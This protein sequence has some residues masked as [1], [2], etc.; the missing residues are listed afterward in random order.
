MN[1]PKVAAYKIFSN[2]FLSIISYD[3]LLH[4]K[5]CRNQFRMVNNCEKIG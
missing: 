4:L 1:I 5:D 2:L 3:T